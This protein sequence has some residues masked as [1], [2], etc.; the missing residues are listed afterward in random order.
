[1]EAQDT[2]TVYSEIVAH[3][4]A[5]GYAYSEWYSGIAA[6]WKE[7]LFDDHQVPREGHAYIAR[8]CYNDED[9]R[10]VETAL[11]KLGCAGDTGGG[12]ETTVY[13]YAYRK[14]TMTNP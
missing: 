9:V 12:D 6:D 11:L 10:V 2:Q 1:M 3:I 8:Q 7:R 14:G 13:V 4:D 5:Q